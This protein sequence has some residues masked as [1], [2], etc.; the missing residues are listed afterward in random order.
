MMKIVE[1]KINDEIIDGSGVDG[2]ALVENP[3][4][5]EDWYWFSEDKLYIVKE[6]QLDKLSNLMKDY[7]QPV[8]ELNDE[9]WVIVKVEGIKLKEEKEEFSKRQFTDIISDPNAPSAL[10]GPDSNSGMIT[11]TRFKYV[12][13][14]DSKNRTFCG[15][16]MSA[17]RVY[18]REDIDA[19][20]LAMS[21]PQ[22]GSYN[23]FEY[24]GSYN[25]R[26]RWVKITYKMD[27][28]I[29]N[30]SS[31]RR[32][33]LGTEDIE[34]LPTVTNATASNESFSILDTID[35]EYVYSTIEEALIRA[36]HIGCS[37]YHEHQLDGGKVG[38][39]ACST[40]KFESYNDYPES[41]KNNAKRALEWVSNYGWGSCGEDTGKQR[42]NQLA[43]GENISEDTI[44]R[45]A[46]FKRHQQHKD[47]PYSE[48][49][50][51]LM[52]DAWGG[53]SGIEW[54]SRKLKEIRKEFT[55]T[56]TKF[57]IDDEK[58]TIVGPA[59][60][61]D[62]MIP[63]VGMT[64]EMYS[65]FFTEDTIRKI[66]EKFLRQKH[67]DK[68]N[69]EHTP[70]NLSDVYVIES[71]II[72]D[73]ENDKSSKFGFKNLPTGTWM[74]S[75]KVEDDTVW[76]SVKQGNIKGFSVEGYFVEKLIFN[77]EDE[78]VQ[79]IINI[80]NNTNDE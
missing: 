19:M 56:K 33:V 77:K 61:P 15:D 10:D 22:F 58:R 27:G 55:S 50:G 75:M 32:G 14:Q 39:M 42:A 79:T 37:G 57:N 38:Y 76:K 45:M 23:I 16:M 18:R 11:R 40:H 67:T 60:I 7:G 78:Q 53:T 1:L 17:N 12:G 13:P 63:R 54:A 21:N 34:Q 68:T 31:S 25:C 26:H 36:D 65:V 49:C 46:S 69:L 74:V 72:E 24:R 9:G 4:I 52:W 66:A 80:L 20:T 28:R 6:D 30:K 8:E 29:L 71:W 44:S 62:K 43:K 3:A 73:P 47:V 35:N 2:I 51:G 5:E 59:M 48:G 64:G 41:A 70:I